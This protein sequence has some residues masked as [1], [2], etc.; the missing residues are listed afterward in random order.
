MTK[1]VSIIARAVILHGDSDAITNDLLIERLRIRVSGD[2]RRF[3]AIEQHNVEMIN[4][5]TAITWDTRFL[6]TSNAFLAI[7]A[8]KAANEYFT[9][10]LEPINSSESANRDRGL[11]I[12]LINSQIISWERV[13]VADDFV[14]IEVRGESL[15]YN[16]DVDGVTVAGGLDIPETESFSLSTYYT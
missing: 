8:L 12:E 2:L 7:I 14:M 13:N 5:P 16:V 9:L 15:G 4:Q 1:S 3:H 10:R 6:S 11:P